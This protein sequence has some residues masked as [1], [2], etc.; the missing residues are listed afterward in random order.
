MT[1]HDE[2]F[3]P[4]PAHL[5]FVP[6]AEGGPTEIED[7]RLLVAGQGTIAFRLTEMAPFTVTVGAPDQWGAPALR[8]EVGFDGATLSERASGRWSRLASFDGARFGLDAEPMCPYWFSV[9][10]HNRRVRYGKGEMRLGTCLASHDLPKAPEPP[11]VDPYAW[12]RAASV[13]TVSPP[14]ASVADVWRDPVTVEPPLRILPRD[15]ITMED[16]ANARGTVAENLTAECQVLY[17]NVAGPGFAL[18]TEDFPQFS[19]AIE[20]SIVNEDGWCHQTLLAKAQ[21]FGKPNPEMTYLRIT[22]GVNQGE[23][24]GIPFVMEIWPAGNYSP[25]HNH[26]GADAVIKVLHGSIH[27]RLFAM[28]S[29]LHQKPFAEADFAAGEVTWITP[30]LNQTHQLKNI[31][32]E[33]C[34]TIQCYQYALSDDTHHPYFDYIQDPGI[35]Y[36]DPNSDMSYLDFKAQMRKEWEARHPVPAPDPPAR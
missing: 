14:V 23:S 10:G 3:L 2:D 27:V 34:V 7:L 15:V 29:P 22:L 21:E 20:E 32:S 5:I 19:Q 9:D 12:L 18:D 8:W 33:T 26:G 24:P 13:L 36:F 11:A 1:H 28:L 6:G 4:R 16:M 31:G 30:R 17:A 25:I 35:G